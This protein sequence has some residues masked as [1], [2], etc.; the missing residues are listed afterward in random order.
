MSNFGK[1]QKSARKKREFPGMT[2]CG[3]MGIKS[4][5]WYWGHRGGGVLQEKKLR[6]VREGEPRKTDT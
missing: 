6:V 3:G 4:W 2:A 1:T 5:K